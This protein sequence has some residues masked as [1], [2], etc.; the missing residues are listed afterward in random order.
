[1]TCWPVTAPPRT[2]GLIARLRTWPVSLVTF[3]DSDP[4]GGHPSFSMCPGDLHKAPADHRLSLGPVW[5]HRQL[6]I[7]SEQGEGH[8]EMTG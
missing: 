1:M 7:S 4:T 8:T 5:C 3:G 2:P 6:S